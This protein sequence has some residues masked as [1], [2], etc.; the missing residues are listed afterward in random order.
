M[1]GIKS[2][3]REGWRGTHKISGC[4]NMLA[5]RKSNTQGMISFGNY[6]KVSYPAVINRTSS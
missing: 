1:V 2:D 5:N 6:V 4:W 3:K